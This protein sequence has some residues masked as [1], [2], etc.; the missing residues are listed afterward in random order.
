MYRSWFRT[1]RK[2]GRGVKKKSKA[3]QKWLLKAA[4]KEQNPFVKAELIYQALE[5]KG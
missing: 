4:S 2:G 5:V 3:V 1:E